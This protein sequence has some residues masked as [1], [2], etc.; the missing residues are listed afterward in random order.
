LA[1]GTDVEQ[2]VSLARAVAGPDPDPELLERDASAL[3]FVTDAAAVF[4]GEAGVDYLEL[5]LAAE[6][7]MTVADL[8]RSLG[9][10]KSVPRLH[11]SE[12]E[13]VAFGFDEPGLPFTTRLYADLEDGGVTAITLRRDPRI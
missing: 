7:G 10:A 2:L 11:P 1:D 9:E 3:P 5:T 12:P 6:A 4:G 8:E 13:Q